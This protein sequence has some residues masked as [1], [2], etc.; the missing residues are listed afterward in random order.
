[1]WFNLVQYALPLGAAGWA[2]HQLFRQPV[3]RFVDLQPLTGSTLRVA[4]AET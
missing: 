1:V 3:D 4:G 2:F